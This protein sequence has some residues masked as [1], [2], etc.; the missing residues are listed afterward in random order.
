MAVIQ[1]AQPLRA[2]LAARE[3]EL[4]GEDLRLR[5]VE[6]RRVEG[7]DRLGEP[8]RSAGE[9][10]RQRGRVPDDVPVA[11]DVRNDGGERAGGHSVP[12]S[13]AGPPESVL[14]TR[15]P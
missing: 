6:E 11:V 12:E 15:A 9:A 2:I 7:V 1:A 8:R 10:R 14:G 5:V 13:A 4:L 3:A